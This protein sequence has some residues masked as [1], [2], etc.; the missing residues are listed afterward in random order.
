MTPGR[1]ASHQ[2]HDWLRDEIIAGHIKPDTTLSEASL[3]L[4]FGISR[5]PVREALQRLSM[6]SLVR[7]FPQRGSVVSRISVPMVLRAQLIREAVEVE[8]VSRAI[9]RIDDAF[10]SDL[11]IELKLQEAFAEAGDFERFFASDQAFHQRISDQC[12]V[13]CVWESLAEI[14]SQLDRARHAELESQMALGVLID[15]HRDVYEAI[16]KGDSA[17]AQEA[18]REHLR[19]I[20]KQLPKTVKTAPELFENVDLPDRE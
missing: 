6:Q 17:A 4:H 5:Q 7:V 15:Q 10:L 12:D 19:R 11:R 20:T 9:D 16:A 2:V 1:P 8:V 18:M 13:Q 3:C 14:R